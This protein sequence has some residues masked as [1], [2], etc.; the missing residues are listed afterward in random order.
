TGVGVGRGPGP[1]AFARSER[2]MPRRSLGRRRACGRALRLGKPCFASFGQAS[3]TRASADKS[4]YA[5]P[6]RALDELRRCILRRE[7]DV[8]IKLLPDIPGLENHMKVSAGV[9]RARDGRE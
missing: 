9:Q 8:T 7:A 3:Q 5:W 6:R 1:P 4:G 2:R